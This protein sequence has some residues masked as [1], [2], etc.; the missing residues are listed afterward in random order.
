VFSIA[1]GGPARQDHF[2]KLV[3]TSGRI[4][5]CSLDTSASQPVA[6]VAFAG[7]LTTNVIGDVSR[8]GMTARS[9]CDATI[10]ASRPEAVQKSTQDVPR[11]PSGGPGASRCSTPGLLPVLARIPTVGLPTCGLAT[12]RMRMAMIVAGVTPPTPTAAVVGFGWCVVG[13]ARSLLVVSDH[14]DVCR[15]AITLTLRAPA[16]IPR[17]SRR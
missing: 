2:G 16:T 6:K 17:K 8:T 5:G 15:V 13:S 1:F 12:R 7:E 10:A 4:T 14:Q 3:S 9:R 11:T